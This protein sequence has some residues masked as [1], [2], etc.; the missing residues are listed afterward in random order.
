M[1]R[2]LSLLTATL[3]TLAA[4][5]ADGRRLADSVDRVKLHERAAAGELGPRIL[6]K[7]DAERAGADPD[8][9]ARAVAKA[10]RC[11]EPSR[12]VRHG[13]KFEAR[14]RL[15]GVHLWYG[16]KCSDAAGVEG[17][18]AVAEALEAFLDDEVHSHEGVAFIEPELVARQRRDLAAP[19]L[20]TTAARGHRRQGAAWLS[21]AEKMPRRAARIDV[22]KERSPEPT[23]R[24]A[25]I[26]ILPRSPLK[27]AAGGGEGDHRGSRPQEPSAR[28]GRP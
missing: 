19:P 2:G 26:V 28:R 4:A 1:L 5:A 14:H 21:P 25:V 15:K 27:S 16:V 13:G 22:V 10:I 7:L 12:V 6:F 8:P 17:G 24:G 20:S 18:S 23:L 3:A 9:L 11:A